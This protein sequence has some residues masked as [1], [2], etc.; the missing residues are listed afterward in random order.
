[1]SRFRHSRWLCREC[2]ECNSK[3]YEAEKKALESTYKHLWIREDGSKIT[4]P[5][6]IVDDLKHDTCYKSRKKASE[7]I[8]YI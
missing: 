3:K 6:E 5:W 8:C 4:D 7:I 2:R 1:M